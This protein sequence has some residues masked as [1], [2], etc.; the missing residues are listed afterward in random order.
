MVPG[1]KMIQ[2]EGKAGA[3]MQR[4]DSAWGSSRNCREAAMTDGM[5][6]RESGEG[7]NQRGDGADHK[8]H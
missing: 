5:S 6:R 4:Q 8:G 2:A 1:R 7:G 3:K